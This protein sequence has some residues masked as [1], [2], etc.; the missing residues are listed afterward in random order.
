MNSNIILYYY[1]YHYHF[2]IWA[3]KYSLNSPR[4]QLDTDIVSAGNSSPL[5]LINNKIGDYD[6]DNDDDDDIDDNNNEDD[7][8]ND[9]NN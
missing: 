9:N 2:F 5:F 3:S 6:D 8:D 7:D 1:H 4:S